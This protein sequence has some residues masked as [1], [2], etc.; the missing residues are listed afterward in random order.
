[1]TG[2]VGLDEAPRPL[3]APR[4]ALWIKDGGFIIETHADPLRH[5]DATAFENTAEKTAEIALGKA[6]ILPGHGIVLIAPVPLQSAVEPEERRQQFGQRLLLHE[7]ERLLAIEVEDALAIH[8]LLPVDV[9]RLVERLAR[10]RELRWFRRG[11]WQHRVEVVEAPQAKRVVHAPTRSIALAW[12]HR[13]ARNAHVV[14]DAIAAEATFDKTAK[15]KTTRLRCAFERLHGL[16]QHL[17]SI[18]PEH[19]ILVIH[20]GDEVMPLAI[21]HI[22]LRVVVTATPRQVK[23]QRAAPRMRVEFPMRGRGLR[24]GCD[25]DVEALL[26]IQLR[27]TL[28]GEGKLGVFITAIDHPAAFQCFAKLRVQ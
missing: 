8:E 27:T 3:Q 4:H 11:R 5:G 23:R 19:H 18:H 6:P 14:D 9:A 26:A 28:D 17:L 2:V 16:L 7:L 22:D 20:A 10:G 21:A 13:T 1:M 15:S 25:E 12:L 24:L